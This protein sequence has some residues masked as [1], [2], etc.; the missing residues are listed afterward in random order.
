MQGVVDGGE[1]VF[2]PLLH[3]TDQRHLYKQEERGEK[4]K[5]EVS[6]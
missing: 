1:E 3:S 6:L 4:M 2:A 5:D